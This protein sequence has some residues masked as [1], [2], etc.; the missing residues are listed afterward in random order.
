MTSP[1]KKPL[2]YADTGVDIEAG[3]RLVGLIQ[4]MMKRTHGPR[5]LGEHG[6]FAGMFRLDFNE[7]LFKRN[8]KDPVLVACT[9]GVGTKVKLACELGIYD[10]V[11]IDCV[12]MNVND[13]IVQ[14]AEPLIFLDYLG[15]HTQVPETTAAI[16]A[17]VAKGCEIS[18]CALIGGECAEMPDI[19]KEGDFDI[20]GFA[21]GVV[22][23]D[24]AIDQSRVEAGD[25]IIGL[26]SS[27]VHSNGFTLARA[28]IEGL[29]LHEVFPELDEEKPLGQV[30][31]E[32]TRIYVEP[33]VKL[34]REYTVKKVV[35]GMSHITGGGIAGNLCRSIGDDVDATISLDSWEI[36]NVFNFLQ[37]HGNIETEEMFRVFNMG[38]GYVLIVRPSFADSI[39]TKLEKLGESP[40][41][42]GEITNGTGKVHLVPGE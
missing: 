15:L 34:L 21:V 10:T 17:G 27:G 31:L 20:A 39:T 23:L 24:R 11:G 7:R 30:L 33:I 16:V 37:K 9:D 12:A 32:P 38:I 5:V 2:T 35:S 26:P 41:V 1:T 6:G 14:G 36:P 13:M 4:S 22:E 19:Y 18:N 42:L 25:I 8:F 40:I 29:D 28:A 3:D